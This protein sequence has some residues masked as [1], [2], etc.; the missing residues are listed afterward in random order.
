MAAVVAGS[1]RDPGAD[2]SDAGRPPALAS[3][4]GVAQPFTHSSVVSRA[5]TDTR[6]VC[7]AMTDSRS[8]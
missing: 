8:L 7:A 4:G 1:V 3:A 2:R 5:S 6:S